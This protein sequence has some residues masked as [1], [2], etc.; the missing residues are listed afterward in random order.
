MVINMHVRSAGVDE[1]HA[2]SQTSHLLSSL[3]RQCA[4]FQMITCFI[5][6]CCYYQQ[7][8]MNLCSVQSERW[9]EKKK[10]KDPCSK[11]SCK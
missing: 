1:L 8:H 2:C 6:S 9:K 10:I 7:P 11:A 3:R 5:F 4:N